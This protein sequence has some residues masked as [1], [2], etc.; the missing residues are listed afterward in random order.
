MLAEYSLR[1]R[2]GICPEALH[3]EAIRHAR[4]L[5]IEGSFL[6]AIAGSY[7]DLMGEEFPELLRNRTRIL[8]ELTLRRACSDAL[9]SLVNAISTRPGESS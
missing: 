2:P 5:K 9:S 8:E 3:S 1:S 7:I 4:L 6:E